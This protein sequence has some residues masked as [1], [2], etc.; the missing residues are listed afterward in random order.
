MPRRTYYWLLARDIDSNKPYLVFGGNTEEEARQK[1]LE[2]LGGVDFEIKPLPTKNL[3]MASSMLKGN[4]LQET[5]S[6]RE[7]GKRIGH[8]RSLKRMLKHRVFW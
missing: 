4:R 3:A 5:K 8:N 1:G 2:M 6:L 7:A